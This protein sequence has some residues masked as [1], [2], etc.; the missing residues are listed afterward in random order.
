MISYILLF[1]LK[2][3]DALG[4]LSDFS[5][6]CPCILLNFWHV[7][8]TSVIYEFGLVMRPYFSSMM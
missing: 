1:S 2:G 7:L 6:S 3:L 5:F 4:V 8:N